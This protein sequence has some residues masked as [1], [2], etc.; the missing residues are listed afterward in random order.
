[1]VVGVVAVGL[2]LGVAVQAFLVRVVVVPADAMRPGLEAGDRLLIDRLALDRRAPTRGEVVVVRRPG[3]SESQGPGRALRSMAEGLGM[4]PL[5]PEVTLVRRVVGLPGEVVAVRDGVLHVDGT[6]MA[7]PYA[8]RGGVDVGPVTVPRGHYWLVGDNRSAAPGGPLAVGPVPR[9]ALLGRAMM[10]LWP[11]TRLLDRV[12]GQPVPAV[13]A[14]RGLPGVMALDM[15][16]R[17][18]RD[19]C[20][21]CARTCASRRHHFAETPGPPDRA[22]PVRAR[23]GGPR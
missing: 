9:T 17:R 6:A 7:E 15:L 20:S 4:V 21:L 18:A 10:V 22:A 13:R 1:M 12:Q 8:R 11:P 14:D 3:E 5:D 23:S 19:P 2:V 16:A